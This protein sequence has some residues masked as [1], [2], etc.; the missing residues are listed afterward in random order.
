M[1]TAYWPAVPVSPS[2][3]RM[4]VPE[5][6]VNET[7]P[8]PA[9]TSK[10]KKPG[11]NISSTI[12]CD[13]AGI[14]QADDCAVIGE[15]TKNRGGERDSR[16]FLPWWHETTSTQAKILRASSLAPEKGWAGSNLISVDVRLISATNKALTRRRFAR[17]ASAKIFTSGWLVRPSNCPLYHPSLLQKT[18]RCW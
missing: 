15:T 4:V 6:A 13:A 12:M 10:H 14:V 16:A 5:P 9:C 8:A 17:A 3:C 18:F 11:G 7:T 2:A 1:A